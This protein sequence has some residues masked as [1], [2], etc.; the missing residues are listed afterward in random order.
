LHAPAPDAQV[1]FV[2]PLMMAGGDWE[3]VRLNGGG[4][5]AG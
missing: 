3:K 1:F 4:I 5:A 2:A